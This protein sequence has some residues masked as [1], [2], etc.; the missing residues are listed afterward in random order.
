MNTSEWRW[1]V[2][3]PDGRI[4]ATGALTWPYPIYSA[5]QAA[6]C[7][8]ARLLCHAHP[9]YWRTAGWRVRAHTP[10]NTHQAW[11]AVDDWL[12]RKE[13]TCPTPAQRS[14][15]ASALTRSS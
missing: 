4:C 11:A 12:H 13:T 5:Q 1:E 3:T 15:S 9:N 7:V 8:L 6:D 2:H 10:D 14:K